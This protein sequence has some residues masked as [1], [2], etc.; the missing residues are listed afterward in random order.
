MR[1]FHIDYLISVG[2]YYSW[3]NI[4]SYGGNINSI[5]EHCLGNDLWFSQFPNSVVHYLNPG[6][7]D[8]TPLKL[9]IAM[10]VAVGFKPFRFF[11]HL[12]MHPHFLS[13]VGQV[14]STNDAV[15]MDGVW[16]VLKILKGELK[17]LH[18]SKFQRVT[19][20]IN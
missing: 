13:L 2:I 18:T 16:N 7:S 20:K 9:C 15:C 12:T 6:I 10:E 14:W 19:S 8:Y 3:H 1:S 17:K 4:D 5:I 11:N